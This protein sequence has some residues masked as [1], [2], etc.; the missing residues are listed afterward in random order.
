MRFCWRLLWVQHNNGNRRIT[1]GRTKLV[2]A[3]RKEA[4]VTL[5][6]TYLFLPLRPTRA[7]TRT[8][9]LLNNQRKKT[10]HTNPVRTSRCEHV[11]GGT[12]SLTLT[13]RE[14]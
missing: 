10:M 8:A 1:N 4:N 2:S 11:N 3:T 12:Q 9:A 13:L 5:Q 14:L 6:Q 7:R